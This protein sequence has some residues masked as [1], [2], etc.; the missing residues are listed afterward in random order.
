MA[1]KRFT[2]NN[3]VDSDNPILPDDFFVIGNVVEDRKMSFAELTRVL[4]NGADFDGTMR[5]VSLDDLKEITEPENASY[6]FHEGKFQFLNAD[7]SQWYSL[8]ISTSGGRTLKWKSESGTEIRALSV[9]QN[10][11]I[12]EPANF[13]NANKFVTAHGGQLQNLKAG[14]GIIGDDFNGSTEKT[15]ALDEV[16][17]TKFIGNAT[18]SLKFIRADSGE[19]VALKCRIVGGIPQFYGEI[20]NEQ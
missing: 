11:V 19:L 8:S 14:K 4:R 2:D 15:W 17:L 9:D 3:P 1:G 6:R 5:F 13:I 18:E 16:F 10:G 12:I 20:V 7:D